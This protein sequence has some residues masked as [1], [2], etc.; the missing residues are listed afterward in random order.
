ML[1]NNFFSLEPHYE[2]SICY[3]PVSNP[4]CPICIIT[5]IDSWLTYYPNGHELKQQ[6]TPEI[7]K[8]IKKFLRQ[9]EQC[10]K[11]NEQRASIC[12]YCFAQFIL[13]E[14]KT[15]NVP[16]III[17]EFLQ[18]FNLWEHKRHAKL[19]TGI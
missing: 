5:Q 9:G 10:I 18:F 17:K 3:E 19:N 4:I 13:N 15:L 6:L 11:C 1:P 8:Y 12:S 14:L 2:C 16:H 7:Q